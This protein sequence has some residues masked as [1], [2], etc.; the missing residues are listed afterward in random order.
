MSR[1]HRSYLSNVNRLIIFLLSV[2]G[3]LMDGLSLR[4]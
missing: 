3:L 4:M 2:A 1:K